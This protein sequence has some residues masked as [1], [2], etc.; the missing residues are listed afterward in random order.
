MVAAIGDGRRLT[1]LADEVL[2]RA[3]GRFWTGYRVP[4]C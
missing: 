3:G 1:A 4:A 2:D